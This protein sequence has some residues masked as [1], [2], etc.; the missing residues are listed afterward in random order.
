MEADLKNIHEIWNTYAE[1]H[2]KY[3]RK[4]RIMRNTQ[5][6]LRKTKEAIS[7]L[8][9]IGM[10]ETILKQ[11]VYEAE[12]NEWWEKRILDNGM[13]FNFDYLFQRQINGGEMQYVVWYEK[14]MD[15]EETEQLNDDKK[16]KYDNVFSF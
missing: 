1:I 4:K 14:G 13:K 11:M 16:K 8:P 9:I 6:F 10:W 12:N 5:S 15:R 2:P 3:F 7:I